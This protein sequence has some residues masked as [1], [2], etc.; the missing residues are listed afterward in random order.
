MSSLFGQQY[1]LD[2]NVLI[3]AWQKYYAPAFCSD[4]WEMLNGLGQQE[5][6]FLPQQVF[7]EITRTEDDLAAWVKKSLIPVY[8]TDG[9][10]TE[11]LRR[12]Y[13]ANPSH[14]LLVDNT[15]QRSMAD[16][17]VIAHAM[18]SNACV[19]TKEHLETAV[20]SKRVKIPNVCQNMGI[21]CIDDYTFIR[22]LNITFSCRIG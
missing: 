18:N 14:V 20:N 17:W 9:P 8:P 15:R 6:I 5:R 13:A 7:D 16:P 2:A 1:C 19:V 3:E 21:R 10:V 22:E 4:Y 12:I 11:C